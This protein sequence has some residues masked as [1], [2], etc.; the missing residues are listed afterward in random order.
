MSTLIFHLKIPVIYKQWL[1][2]LQKLHAI[3]NNNYYCNHLK[4]SFCFYQY[5]F[6][7]TIDVL[8]MKSAFKIIDNRYQSFNDLK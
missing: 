6:Q 8:C 5:L 7:T 4:S 2:I 1:E 3:I